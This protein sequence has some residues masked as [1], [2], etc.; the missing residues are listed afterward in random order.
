M[1]YRIGNAMG[2]P[3][4]LGRTRDAVSDSSLQ[5]PISDSS[6]APVSA[7]AGERD[8]LRASIID[9]CRWSEP[10]TRSGAGELGKAVKDI[11]EAGGT[12]DGVRTVASR[13]RASWS[14]S[15]VTPSSIAKWWSQYISPDPH[16]APASLAMSEGETMG[17]NYALTIIDEIEVRVQAESDLGGDR[18][19]VEEAITAW[20]RRNSLRETDVRDTEPRTPLKTIGAS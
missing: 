3:I 1:G 20:S 17:W 13:M 8:L 9:E 19:L 5:S 11:A 4:G 18:E 15:G 12:A 10:L 14:Q 7:G 6:L 16:T 2:E